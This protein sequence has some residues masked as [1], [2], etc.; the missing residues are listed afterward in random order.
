MLE[1]LYCFDENYNKQA[2]TSIYSLLEKSSEKL[3][4]N[5]IHKSYND[6]DF[7]QIKFWNM[8]I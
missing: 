8:I 7:Y 3:N 5:I 1:V 6:N 2:F 4:V